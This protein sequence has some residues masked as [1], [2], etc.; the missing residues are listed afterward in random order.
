MIIRGSPDPAKAIS[1]RTM[2]AVTLQRLEATDQERYASNTLIDCYDIL[3]MLMEARTLEYG[4]KIKGEGAHQQL[5]DHMANERFIDDG[6]RIFLQEMREYRNR[7][8]YEGFMVP[9][10]YIRQNLARIKRTIITLS[11][12]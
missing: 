3:H 11:Q 12:Q 10:R 7:I 6:T 5:I 2:A 4:M 1:L 8:S 9:A